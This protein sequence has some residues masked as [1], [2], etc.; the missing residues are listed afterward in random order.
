M[1][2]TMEATQSQDISEM[3]ESPDV[4]S[5]QEKTSTSILSAFY[6]NYWLFWEVTRIIK[7]EKTH[8]SNLI[9]TLE[10]TRAQFKKLNLPEV[11]H[12]THL[13]TVD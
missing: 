6:A 10:T 1:A 4:R 5:L 11:S 8:P 9:Q 7:W 13:E 3:L 12:D 2:N